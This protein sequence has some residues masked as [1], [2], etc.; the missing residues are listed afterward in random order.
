[1][2]I[3]HQLTRWVNIM[4]FADHLSKADIQ[5]FNQ[6]RKAERNKKESK[7]IANTSTKKNNKERLSQRELKELMDV[8]KEVYKRVRGSWR[9]R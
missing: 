8:N 2:L 3:Q 4:L 9:R 5:K 1:M 7:P 6:L